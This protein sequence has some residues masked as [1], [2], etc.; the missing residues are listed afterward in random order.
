MKH[1]HRPQTLRRGITELDGGNGYIAKLEATRHQIYIAQLNASQVSEIKER[2]DFIGSVLPYE[3]DETIDHSIDEFRAIGQSRSLHTDLGKP[4]APKSFM[5]WSAAS[6]DPVPH[7]I[8]RALLPSNPDAPWWKKM[9]SA[10][11]R[12]IDVADSGPQF[13]PP[14]LADASLGKGVTIYVLDDG[15]DTDNVVCL[16]SY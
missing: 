9:L 3:F 6:L 1:P 2:Y 16:F 8:P 11:P 7:L 13:D 12:D 15:F 10:P 5:G 14:Y 4:P